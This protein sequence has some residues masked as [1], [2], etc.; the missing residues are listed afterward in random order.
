MSEPAEG[1][2][3][4]K[5]SGWLAGALRRLVVLQPG[6]GPV[7]LA[8]FAMVFCVFTSYA[9]LRPVRE[10][11]GITSGVENLPVL[12]WAVFG[13][14]LLVQPIYGWLISRFRRRVFLPW[15]YGFFVANLV[16]FYL[17]FN[18]QQDH[19]WIARFYYVW[20][21]VY[22]LFSLAT[23]WSLMSDVLTR[24]QAGRMF[25]FITAGISLGGIVG[26]WMVK[27]L[28]KP[29]AA[30]NPLAIFGHAVVPSTA[31]EAGTI[32]LLL[33]SALMLLVSLVFLAIVNRWDDRHGSN[34]G[35]V[36]GGGESSR[37]A[38][39]VLA[40]SFAAFPQ[41][42]KSGYLAGIAL[43]IFLLTWITTPL[44]IQQQ[45]F[46]SNLTE[47]RPAAA[48]R[49][50]HAA[51]A[52]APAT[53]APSASAAGVP[54]AAA[55][56]AAAGPAHVAEAKASK[57]PTCTP[58]AAAAAPLRFL[59]VLWPWSG[60]VS[61]AWSKG[62][63]RTLPPCL[64][65]SSDEQTQFNADIDQWVQMASLVGQLLIFGHIF[66]WLGLRVTLTVLPLVMVIGYIG[67][68]FLPVFPVVVALFAT[69][70][71]VDYVFARP[72]RESLFTVVSRDEKYK[73]KSLIDTFV[74]RG[75]DATNGSLKSLLTGS[76]GMSVSGLGWFGAA[77]SAIWLILAYG[78]GGAQE[79]R[80]S[81][82]TAAAQP[83]ASTSGG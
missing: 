15:V 9:V 78:L 5:E 58:T 25:G 28:V 14:M 12:F 74:Y 43:F 11:M 7:L 52:A 40:T 51:P 62:D 60:R 41:V 56:G 79:R 61:G 18:F 42:A 82:Q 30:V 17:W 67:L 44:Y 76:L 21:S 8:A 36:Q 49:G 77:L 6:E 48:A 4:G 16:A 38:W 75:G 1:S 2:A 23:F 33:I 45:T 66:R 32:N 70:R 55:G 19:T 3:A 27:N 69:R 13:V 71:I 53:P 54:A 80:R 24:E 47:A 20:V 35:Q 63:G 31:H 10:T 37:G 57:P 46:I 64:F 29:L 81:G 72:S 65:H 39:S 59:D 22:S 73:A 26:P 34:R 50:E 83:V 68:A